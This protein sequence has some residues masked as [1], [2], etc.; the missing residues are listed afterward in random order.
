MLSTYT[1]A[2]Y[3]E[4]NFIGPTSIANPD[5]SAT[6][7]TSIIPQ[8]PLSTL[9]FYNITDASAPTYGCN[10]A[11]NSITTYIPGA[12]N[13]YYFTST[14]ILTNSQDAQVFRM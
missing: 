7:V 14:F 8:Y 12:G 2:N 11:G 13:G 1:T 4:S 6:M 3:T 10:I 9:S 5:P